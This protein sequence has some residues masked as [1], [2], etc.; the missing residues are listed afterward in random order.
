MKHLCFLFFISLFTFS[1]LSG[2]TDKLNTINLYAKDSVAI[3]ADLYHGEKGGDVI[4]LCH[5]ARFS[6]GEYLETGP[7]LA[8][9]GFNCMA[10]DQR[11]GDQVNGV[12]NQ[13]AKRAQE[14][15]RP[16]DFLDAE[17]DILAAIEFYHKLTKKKIILVGSSY[18]ASLALKIASE[19]DLVK[20]VI[21]F[22]PGEYF[23]EKLN[24]SKTIAGLSK[25]CFVTSSKREAE[26]V[27]SVTAGIASDLFVHFVPK[28]KGFHGSKALWSE[29]EGNEEY[30]SA[31]NA[32]FKQL[33]TYTPPP[34]EEKKES[35]TNDKGT[36]KPT[37]NRLL[38]PNAIS[39]KR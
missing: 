24:L 26:A 33:E 28:S 22:S 20:A 8:E 27:K 13:T 21:A 12:I 30:W 32:F 2:Q 5:Q 14:V 3:K 39:P 10:I 23:G 4:L 11:S 36:V 31:L 25:P 6:R 17:Q 1:F 29:N 37:G 7:R 18:S 34:S 15:G 16:T 9:Y 35:S 38:T 19:N